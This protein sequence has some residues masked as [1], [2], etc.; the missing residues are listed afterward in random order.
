MVAEFS[1][2]FPDARGASGR[3]ELSVMPI[4]I[5]LAKAANITKS[6]STLHEGVDPEDDPTQESPDVSACLLPLDLRRIAWKAQLTT[7]TAANDDPE[8]DR[9]DDLFAIARLTLT[10]KTAASGDPTE[11]DPEDDDCRID[12]LRA[13]TTTLTESTGDQESDPDDDRLTSLP[14]REDG[15]VLPLAYRFAEV[16]AA[17]DPVLPYD[18][19]SQL[20]VLAN[21]ESIVDFIERHYQRV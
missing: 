14:N 13:M 3:R 4:D 5:E 18:Q 11:T 17:P 12:A 21:G 9:D 2:A 1:R 7:E 10:T 20:H 6:T 19:E 8:Q 16:S 15:A